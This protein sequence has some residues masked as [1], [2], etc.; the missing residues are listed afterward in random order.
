MFRYI[1]TF[2]E[3]KKKKEEKEIIDV[4]EQR[5]GGNFLEW[6]TQ[7]DAYLYLLA[8]LYMNYRVALVS[9]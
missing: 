8:L 2:F 7:T 9:W 1:L 6:K 5:G 4:Q 3:K